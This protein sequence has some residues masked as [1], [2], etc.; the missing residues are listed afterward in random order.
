MGAG[1]T[2]G[3]T[4]VAA[5]RHC[6]VVDRLIKPRHIEQPCTLLGTAGDAND[7]ASIHVLRDLCA[8]M[9]SDTCVGMHLDTHLRVGFDRYSEMRWP[10]SRHQRTCFSVR[11]VTSE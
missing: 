7:A 6:L 9:C 10:L 1:S 2:D 11:A 8:S 4:E 3:C 5:A